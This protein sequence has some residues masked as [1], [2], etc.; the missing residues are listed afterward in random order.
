MTSRADQLLNDLSPHLPPGWRA[1]VAVD[2]PSVP[3]VLTATDKHNL[4]IAN[5]QPD[6]F[7]PL[8]SHIHYLQYRYIESQGPLLTSLPSGT[9]NRHAMAHKPKN[10]RVYKLKN[11]KTQESISLKIHN[12][13][14]PKVNHPSIQRTLS[15][16]LA[17][18]KVKREI[19]Y[20][21]D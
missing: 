19:L 17:A 21:G 1:E 7:I 4:V 2:L 16:A 11:P 5:I 20:V 14:N 18:S 12:P 9:E 10:S 8:A 13:K 3:V 6:S 15:S